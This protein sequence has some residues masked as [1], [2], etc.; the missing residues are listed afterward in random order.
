MLFPA[1]L[2]GCGHMFF[3]SHTVWCACSAR[4]RTG[5]APTGHLKVLCLSPPFAVMN[6][7]PHTVKAKLTPCGGDLATAVEKSEVHVVEH[8]QQL[9]WFLSSADERALLLLHVH[10]FK[11][12][13]GGVVLGEY[14]TV[15]R[16]CLTVRRLT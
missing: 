4:A 6:M 2:R 1:R 13:A 15:L 16:C 9:D 3:A 10:R 11:R 12:F 5:A 8:D 7:L 14:V